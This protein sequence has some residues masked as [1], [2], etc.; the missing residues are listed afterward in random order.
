MKTNNED[1]K[2]LI[3]DLMNGSRNLKEYPVIESRYVENEYEQNKFCNRAYEEIYNA[4]Q[5]L[6]RR[7]NAEEDTD[8]KCIISNLLDIQSYLC[9]KM[10]DYAVYF[11]MEQEDDNEKKILQLYRGLSEIRKEKFMN[12]IEI[13]EN[14]LYDKSKAKSSSNNMKNQE[15]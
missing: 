7:L 6:C 9:M 3:Y 5:R 10:Y 14:S 2:Q 13:I 8:V 4:N 1:F 15:I 11:T 12:L